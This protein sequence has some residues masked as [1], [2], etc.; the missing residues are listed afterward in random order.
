MCEC[1]RRHGVLIGLKFS[2]PQ[3]AK[4]LEVVEAAQADSTTSWAV[5]VSEVVWRSRRGRSSRRSKDRQGSEGTI[6]RILDL[7]A[8]ELSLPS[9]LEVLTR[10]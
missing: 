10:G 1:F 7:L 6:I 5:V 9:L 3:S 4:R 2:L 8:L